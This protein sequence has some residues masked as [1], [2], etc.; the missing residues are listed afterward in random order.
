MQ[1]K[2]SRNPEIARHAS[3]KLGEVSQARFRRE[4][5]ILRATA[6]NRGIMGVTDA[7]HRSSASDS[8]S[9]THRAATAH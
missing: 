2:A 7:W 3:E 5:G 4:N 8:L 9:R 1:R 6:D